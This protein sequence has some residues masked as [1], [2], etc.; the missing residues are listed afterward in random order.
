MQ[1]Q[2]AGVYLAQADAAQAAYNSTLKNNAISVQ[3]L[4]DQLNPDRANKYAGT[5]QATVDGINATFDDAIAKLKSYG[6]TADQISEAEADRAL[7]I[8]NAQ[9]AANDTYD[10]IVKQIADGMSSLSGIS[11]TLQSALDTI[12]NAEKSTIDQLNAAAIAAGRSGAAEKDL[13]LVREYAAQ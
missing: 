13:A 7:A 3:Q 5:W 8:S 11:N 1:W 12:A 4:L 10:N 6:A 2:Q 9:K